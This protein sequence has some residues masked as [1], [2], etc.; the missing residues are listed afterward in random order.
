MEYTVQNM[1][2]GASVTLVA[3]NEA[4]ARISACTAYP[5]WFGCWLIIRPQVRRMVEEEVSDAADDLAD[6]GDGW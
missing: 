1:N 6:W 3:G 4:E 2:T 5:G